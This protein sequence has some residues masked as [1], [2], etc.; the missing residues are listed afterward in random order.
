MPTTRTRPGPTNIHRKEQP[1]LRLE[2]RPEPSRRMMLASPLIAA[3][4]MLLTGSVLC[5]FLR[6]EPLHAFY[7]YFITAA[8]TLYGVG[9]L[10]LKATPLILGGVGLAIGFRANVA[11]IGAD[12]QLTMGA[13]AAGAVALYFDDVQAGWL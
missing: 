12:G 7:V 11:N 8:T 1:M 10:L 9:E 3:L 5:F 13:I 2:P 4:A 6:Q